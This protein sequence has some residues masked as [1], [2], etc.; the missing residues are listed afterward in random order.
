MAGV[1]GAITASNGDVGSPG[2]VPT[3][4]SDPVLLGDV[5]LDGTVDFLDISPFI[6]VL[7]TGEFQVEADL[8]ESGVV[9]FL[10]ISPFINVLS[11]GN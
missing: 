10:D 5:S 1:N 4:D 2:T 8:D 7:S 6:T 3:S 9:D 11:Q